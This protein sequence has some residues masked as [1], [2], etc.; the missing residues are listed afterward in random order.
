MRLGNWI[1]R[2]Y[3][4]IYAVAFGIGWVWAFTDTADYPDTIPGFLLG[5][6]ILSAFVVVELLMFTAPSVLVYLLTLALIFRL[7]PGVPRR[8]AALVLCPLIAGPTW[9]IV[10]DREHIASSTQYWIDWLTAVVV[11]LACG[12]AVRVDVFRQTSRPRLDHGSPTS[13]RRRLSA[14][15]LARWTLA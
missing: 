15:K 6:P 2:N 3:A 9:L 4:I 14:R 1:A 5:P 10:A 12:L 7:Y 11:V 13:R 8:A